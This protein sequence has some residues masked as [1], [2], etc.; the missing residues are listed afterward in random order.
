MRPDYE[1]SIVNITA[2]L[3]KHYGLTPFHP[4]LPKLDAKLSEGYKHVVLLVLDGLGVNAMREHLS[5][6]SFLRRHQKDTLTSVFPA[7]TTAATTAILTGKTPY[8]TGF[9]GWFQ[10]FKDEDIHY[11]IFT[12]K[13]FYD[14]EKEIP[15][16]FYDKHF[17]RETVLDLLHRADKS[18]KT[19]GV[20]PEIVEENGYRTYEEGFKRCLDFQKKHDRTLTY[21]Y[22]VEPDKTEHHTGMTGAPTKT[23]V[24]TLNEHVET[25]REQIGRDTLV[26]VT[27]D[28]GLVDVTDIALFDYHDL[29][30]TFE[31]LPANEPRMTNFF[32][33]KGMKEHFINFF[34][35]HFSQYF[36]LFTKEELL[37][38][39]LLGN[40]EKH[41]LVD[42]CLGDFIAVAKDRFF[43]RL[44]DEKIHLGHHAGYTRGEMEVPL[45]YFD[46]K[47]G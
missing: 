32:I 38:S 20:F 9:L 34:N 3:M 7:T 46:R 4:T 31:H 45:I 39:K 26:V 18:L 33:K 11:E 19:K 12:N 30:C 41:P 37:T 40:G 1:R 15:N 13:D 25:F 5:E 24:Q 44:S 22:S 2:S 29:T 27:A 42:Y 21:L 14:E 28:H 10:Y 36:D 47:D 23:M 43:F 6:D 16:G 35:E 8:E 17:K